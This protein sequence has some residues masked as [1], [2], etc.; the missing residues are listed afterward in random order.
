VALVEYRSE[1]TSARHIKP[2]HRMSVEQV[3][4]EWEPMGFALVDLI[5]ELPTQHLF[6]FGRAASSQPAP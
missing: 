4:E 5:E 1:G 3:L 2:E 6:L